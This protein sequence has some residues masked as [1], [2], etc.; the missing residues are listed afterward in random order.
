M[1]QFSAPFLRIQEGPA[2]NQN[3]IAG[4]TPIAARG[5]QPCV[6]SQLRSGPG[7]RHTP[8]LLAQNLLRPEPRRTASQGGPVALT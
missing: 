1:V 8:V 7:V 5:H 2:D 6:Q 4:K 3:H